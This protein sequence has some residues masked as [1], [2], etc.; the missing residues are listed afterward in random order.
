[1]PSRWWSIPILHSIVILFSDFF[2]FSIHSQHLTHDIRCKQ[3]DGGS[4][5]MEA[6]SGTHARI[7]ACLWQ[8]FQTLFSSRCFLSFFLFFFFS[9]ACLQAVS[10]EAPT[11]L[12]LS[13]CIQGARAFQCPIHKR[14]EPSRQPTQMLC[15][16]TKGHPPTPCCLNDSLAH[17]TAVKGSGEGGER[18]KKSRADCEVYDQWRLESV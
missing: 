17:V 1:M 11:S 18:K 6:D 15:I 2:S 9:C 8:P 4:E 10:S 5:A 13:D 7:A 3:T 14:A 16:L 12:H